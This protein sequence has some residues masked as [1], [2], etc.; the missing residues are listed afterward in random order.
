M[1][2][3]CFSHGGILLLEIVMQIEFHHPFQMNGKRLRFRLILEPIFML[4]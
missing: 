4:T 1:E 3:A 2:D